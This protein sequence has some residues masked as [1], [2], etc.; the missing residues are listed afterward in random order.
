MKILM[1]APNSSSFVEKDYSLLSLVHETRLKIAWTLSDILKTALQVPK[2]DLCFFWFASVRF[3]PI[4]ILAKAMGKKT[5]VVAGGYDVSK[6]AEADYG[7]VNNRCL[8]SFLRKIILHF[9]DKVITVSQSNTLEAISNA[10]VSPK[11]IEKIYLAVDKPEGQLT[12]W[13]ERKNQVLFIACCDETSYKIKGF[14]TFVELAKRLP[15]YDFVHMGQIKIE[16]FKKKC[17]GIPN[18]KLLGYVRHMGPEFSEVMNQSK[19]ILLASKIESFGASVLE[20]A[21]HGCVPVVSDRFALPEIYG[22]RGCVCQLGNIE[23]FADAINEVM[24]STN[25]PEDL[26]KYYFDKYN[27]LNRKTSLVKTLQ[28]LTY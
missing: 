25:H 12:S 8:S 17:Q 18:I 10:Q 9:A 6:L 24:N 21:L 1:V 27:V 19:V 2:Y 7:G 15:H 5:V 28:S 22:E 23:S 26:Q 3:L 14:D 16:D 11:N 13:E 20:G 4:F